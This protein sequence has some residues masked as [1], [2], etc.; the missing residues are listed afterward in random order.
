MKEGGGCLIKKNIRVCAYIF[1]MTAQ[2]ILQ[3]FTQSSYSRM[4]N[5]SLQDENLLVFHMLWCM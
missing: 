2:L 1:G 4:H 5:L 3:W